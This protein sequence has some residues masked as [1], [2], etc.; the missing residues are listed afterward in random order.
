MNDLHS[1]DIRAA[2]DRRQLS[3]ALPLLAAGAAYP[4]TARAATASPGDQ[5]PIVTHHRTKTIGGINMFY[6]EAGPANAPIVLL[7]HGFPTSSH[8]FRNLI[9]ELADRYHLIDT[10]HFAL[11][12]KSDEM[13]PLIRDFLYRKVAS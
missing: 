10:G 13:V 1:T 8:M 2:L 4:Q 9:P 12:D 6:R 11:E 5:P 3:F 7:L